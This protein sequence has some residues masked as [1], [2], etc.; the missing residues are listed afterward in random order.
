MKQGFLI[1]E[2]G[3]T[4]EGNIPSQFSGTIPGEVV[5][6][7]GMCGYNESLTDPSFSGQILVFTFP[8]IGNYGIADK[9]HWESEKVHAAGVVV[10]GDCEKW[11]HHS[12]LWSLRQ[13]LESQNVP[14]LSG[15]DTRALTKI[16]RS[17]GSP[18][19][20][21]TD[22]PNRPIFKDPN[23]ENLVK[24]VS[25]SEKKVYGKGNKRVIAVDC[26]MKESMMRHL[27]RLPLEIVRVPY[28]YD[29]S[30]DEF[31]GVFLSNG[32]G[33]PQKCLETLLILK[34]A[35]ERKNPI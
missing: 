3:A 25:I 9:T 22:S 30:Q 1:L 16:I 32:P 6:T 5:F 17:K 34:K 24:K 33:D 11:S 20:A 7:T 2:N 18:L 8:L 35:M 4:F 21:I 13:W 10:A 23:R 31:D 12:G 29:Y 14:L 28:N 26:G 15:V 19:G 27:C